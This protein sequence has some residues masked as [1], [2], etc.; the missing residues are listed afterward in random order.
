MSVQPA[1]LA[2]QRRCLPA[3]AGQRAPARG[4]HGA[5]EEAGKDWR[6]GMV[7]EREEHAAHLGAVDKMI[8]H[9]DIE[10]LD[11][12]RV[13]RGVGERESP[14]REHG[15]SDG[16]G[17]APSGGACERRTARAQC[18]PQVSGRAV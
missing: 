5:G 13:E 3:P 10:E 1:T 2:R 16:H 17:P 11:V 4:E 18:E 6:R 15:L 14:S 7:P 12:G 8:V 9:L